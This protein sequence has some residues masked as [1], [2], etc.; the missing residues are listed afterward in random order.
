MAK[1]PEHVPEGRPV[2]ELQVHI[3][4]MHC[5]N[6]PA[7]VESRIRSLPQV[8]R[9]KVH[10]P[11][12][13]ATITLKDSLSPQ[14]LQSV[15]ARDGYTVSTKA[16]SPF[17]NSR[18]VAEIAGV[19][20]LLAAAALA[21]QH[22]QLLPRGFGISDEMS[23]GVIFV[24]GLV[25]SLSSCLAVTGGLMVALAA[26]YNQANA[27]LSDRQRLV[28][29]VYFNAGRLVSYPLLGGVIGAIGAAL[30]LSAPVSGAL[31]LLAAVVMI[32]LGLHMLRIIP[33]LS[34]ILPGLPRAFS[35]RLQRAASGKTKRA[36]FALGAMTFFLPCG[37]TQALQLYVLAKA[38][39]IAGALTMLAFALG[40]LPALV[41]LAAISSFARGTFQK[42][43]TRFAGAA[44]ILLGLLNIQ[45][46]L[47]LTSQGTAT[48]LAATQT[49]LPSA[50][51]ITPP[52]Q[53]Q[54]IA[55][56]VVGLDYQPNQFTVR[57]G[58]PV[59]W[60]I[61][62][63]EAEGCGRV[64]VAPRLGIQKMLSDNSTTLISFTPTRTGEFPFNCG[65]G[66][67]TPGSKITVVAAD[68]GVGHDE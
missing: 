23:Y 40:T 52:S 3:G 20:V 35:E 57:L 25:A 22:L 53:P 38:S 66:M 41:S 30:T 1:D 58:Q 55:M 51:Q 21:L 56:K 26:E 42:H 67:M 17:S 24:I 37:F 50:G 68:K 28:P 47:V 34:S 27:T 15:V 11:A 29:L 16:P 64:L 9:V 19:F 32:V 33:S 54:R 63:S 14:E 46:G 6:C 2:A 61:D 13:R 48:S 49:P 44:V 4:G 36:A 12:G 39:F 62:G 8:E 65:M 60:A 10:Y 59:E 45:S 5:V 31:T 43:F 18:D 7:L